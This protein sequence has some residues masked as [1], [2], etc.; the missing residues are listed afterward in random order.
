MNI[1]GW[2]FIDD[3]T[4]HSD[5]DEGRL[6]YLARRWSELHDAAEQRIFAR[7]SDMDEG[8]DYEP[9]ECEFCLDGEM[10]VE[11]T[12][13]RKRPFLSCITCHAPEFLVGITCPHC[14]GDGYDK[15]HEKFAVKQQAAY[16]AEI[17]VIETML[18]NLGARMM[19]PYEHWNEDERYME[20]MER[21]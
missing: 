13:R 3:E 1:R 2:T 21:D 9:E 19:R 11:S 8:R 7:M 14:G 16:D 18:H 15:S 17:E 10:G 12:R 4:E 5:Y 20:Y 6:D